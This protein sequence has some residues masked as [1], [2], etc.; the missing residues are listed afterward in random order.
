MTWRKL[1]TDSPR[2]AGVALVSPRGRILFL[3]RADGV[4]ELPGG[5]IEPGERPRQAAVREVVEETGFDSFHVHRDGFCTSPAYVLYW[6]SMAAERAPKLT[7]HVE[8]EWALP[9]APPEP[10]HPGLRVVF[11]PNRLSFAD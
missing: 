7:E 9:N 2:A 3:Q 4:W 10:L 11:Q 5:G 6:G 1:Y 8:F